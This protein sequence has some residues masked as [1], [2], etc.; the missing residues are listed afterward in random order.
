[1][2]TKTIYSLVGIMLTLIAAPATAQFRASDL[3]YVPAVAHTDGAN[4]SVW[5]SDVTITNAE[6]EDSIDVALVFIETGQ[7]NNSY[8]FNDRSNWLGGR[9]GNEFGTIDESLADIPPG[10]FII[11]KDILGGDWPNEDGVNS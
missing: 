3:I 5:T 6:S 4:E 1:M 7:R 10:G 11:L 2:R 8:L 9:T